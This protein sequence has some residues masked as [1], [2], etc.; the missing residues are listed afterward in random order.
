MKRLLSFCLTV[1][2]FFGGF[3][4]RAWAATAVDTSTSQGDFY[5]APTASDGF[6]IATLSD[7]RV[8]AGGQ[9]E[10]IR[11]DALI[12]T[13]GSP[14]A[15]GNSSSV[16]YKSVGKFKCEKF[17]KNTARLS[18]N[19]FNPI[20]PVNVVAP[21]LNVISSTVLLQIGAAKIADIVA[22]LNQY[23]ITG[24]FDK[25]TRGIG[26]TIEI[27]SIAS[28]TYLSADPSSFNVTPKNVNS[29]FTSTFGFPDPKTWLTI[30]TMRGFYLTDQGRFTIA[31]LTE[32][33][34][35]PGLFVSLP[36]VPF[37]CY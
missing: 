12:T 27:G 30:G 28:Q 29:L 18:V 21:K 11:D 3:Q 33:E 13:T 36:F 32:I 5:L 35:T 19:F 22:A 9:A 7:A 1:L 10:I 20:D 24:V 25:K 34:D 26:Q 37:T 15:I 2:L 6:A 4:E 17:Q 23:K 31:E 8:G 16:F 14:F